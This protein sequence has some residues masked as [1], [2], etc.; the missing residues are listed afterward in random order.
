VELISRIRETNNERV[1]IYCTYFRDF[2]PNIISYSGEVT[3]TEANTTRTTRGVSNLGCAS[4]HYS[5]INSREWIDD[6]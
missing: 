6:V 5:G 4:R 2:L 1:V 3:A